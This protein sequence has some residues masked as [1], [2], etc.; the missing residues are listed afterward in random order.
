MRVIVAGD[1]HG[2]WGVVGKLVNQ[3]HPD[4]VLQVGDFGYFPRLTIERKRGI[5]DHD[6]LRTLVRV[7]ERI[8][9]PETRIKLRGTP[10]HWCDGNHEDFGALKQL[11]F[12]V[13]PETS[14][15]TLYPVP[16]PRGHEVAPDCFYQERGSTI[17]LPDGRVV[18]FAGGAYSI[19]KKLRTEGVD[20]FPE[21]TLSEW[22]LA[23]FPDVDVDIV[24]SHTAPDCFDLGPKITR[25]MTV[26]D[27]TSVLLTR[28]FER[29]RPKWWYF[30]HF[31]AYGHGEHDGCK[32]TVIG[33]SQSSYARWW[34]WLDAKD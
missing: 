14:L 9:D 11:V 6:G 15:E 33:H 23:R 18:L 1:V 2:D 12:G 13:D 21:E 3:Q 17:T 28:V 4:L 30:G 25:G 8:R 32:W 31:H 5:Y 10:L 29:Y 27:P 24:V 16:R 26:W 19:D 34:T 7:E 20:W 22:D